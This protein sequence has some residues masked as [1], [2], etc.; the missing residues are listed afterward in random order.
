VRR[1]LLLAG[2]D[3]EQH[4]VELVR[5]AR[6]VILDD[7]VLQLA[8]LR[9][10]LVVLAAED[11]D[12]I[13]RILFTGQQRLDVREDG[14]LLVGHVPL[15]LGGVFVEKAHDGERHVV[16]RAVHRLDQLA[17]NGRQAEVEEVA[18]RIVEVVRKRPHRHPGSR[19]RSVAARIHLHIDHGEEGRRIDLVLGAHLGDGLVAESQSDS[20]AAHHL[21][22]R[23]SVADQIA[24]PVLAR[25]SAIS[26]HTYRYF[27]RLQK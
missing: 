15:H 20:E 5:A 21:Q 4:T 6:R 3:V 11:V 7:D 10:D 27:Y 14:L 23:V 12:R 24:H 17:A 18:V 19:L 9:I 16:L 26:I 8:Q 2:E 1:Q 22:N 13:G 25:V